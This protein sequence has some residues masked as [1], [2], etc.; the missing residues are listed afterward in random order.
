M[1]DYEMNISE[2]TNNE[3]SNRRNNKYT[4]TEIWSMKKNEKRD[5]QNINE[6]C[7]GFCIEKVIAFRYAGR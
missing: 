4:Y 6:Q 3:N 2:K 1:N 7:L 5:N